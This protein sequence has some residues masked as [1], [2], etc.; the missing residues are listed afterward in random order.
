MVATPTPRTLTPRALRVARAAYARVIASLGGRFPGGSA[1]AHADVFDAL[2][3]EA[4]ADGGWRAV[5][6]L[7]AAEAGSLL[8]VALTPSARSRRS[9]ITM[10]FV[11]D[12][13]A[14]LRA[15]TRARGFTVVTVATLALG[16]GVT[17]A[18]FAVFDAV[19]LR[20]LPYHDADRLVQVAEWPTEGGGGNWTVS[21]AA[22]L[23]WKQRASAFASLDARVTGS[24]VLTDAA[25]PQEVRVARVTPG[26]FHTLGATAMR[27]RVFGDADRPGGGC[28]AV[29]SHRLWSLRYAASGTLIGAPIALDGVPCAVIGVLGADTAFD[30][31]PTDIYTLMEFTAASASDNSRSMTALARLSDG[32]SVERA[33]AD[34]EAVAAAVNPERG[35]EGEGWTARVFPLRDIVVRAG[36]RQL[37][38]VSLAAVGVVLLICC[39]NVA[40]LFL[41]RAVARRHEAA[42]RRALG[43]SRWR[44]ARQYLA[45]AL[46]IAVAGGAAGVVIGSWTLRL[47]V[48][49]LPPGVL[50]PELVVSIDWRV[51]LFTAAVAGGSAVVC[52]LLPLASSTPEAADIRSGGRSMTPSR[53]TGLLQNGLL[54]GEIALATVVLGGAALLLVSYTR[55]MDQPPGFDAEGVFT[56][57][58]AL[59]GPRYA[60]PAAVSAFFERTLDATR[61]SPGVRH[62]A[63]VTSLPLGGWLYGTRFTID[64]QASGRVPP[65]A[66]I[67][68]ATPGYFET[69]GIALRSGRSFDASDSAGA[70][71]VAIVNE[72]L[73]RRFVT[74]G[75]ALGR[76][77]R[78]GSP[79]APPV[80]IIG[81]T[82]D[83]KTYGLA[84]APLATPEIY[85]PH[86]QLSAPVMFVAI[87]SDS[88]DAGA[89][90][91]HL[92]AAVRQADPLVPLGAITPMRDRVGASAALQRFRATMIALLGAA[93]CGLA[94]VGVYSIRAR[95]TQARMSEFGLRIAL[96]ATRG[97]I[98]ALSLRS[99]GRLIGLGLFIGLALAVALT[100]LVQSWLFGIDSGQAWIL[101]VPAAL[102]GVA[103]LA[104]SWIPARR[105][106]RSD[107][108]AMLRRV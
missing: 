37:A 67:Q 97:D 51:L 56:A 98:I 7:W 1:D 24:A 91:S 18:G 108:T 76:F 46:L 96:G 66:H 8:R 21:P 10:G 63:A 81:V 14:S 29:V 52:G 70:A 44:T 73:A 62:A 90:L 84:D 26:Y 15:L 31:S 19:L 95:H 33:A 82:A 4:F 25:D 36:A 39:V 87:R 83:V 64:G 11:Q 65:S 53:R 35:A 20:P 71:P 22:F 92:R 93:A 3:Q 101:A 103:G 27:G 57:R 86:T 6:R 2:Q 47:F 88:E 79:D 54:V 78:L 60:E 49:L 59:S 89:V 105:A 48:S 23:E 75:D 42:V 12:L 28:V 85:V 74:G 104:A 69:F 77:L 100:G 13:R 32:V 72:T 17:A 5:C 50:P 45:E 16:V 107:P 43:A 94:L 102:L 58:L 30:R 55:L 40:A 38:V 9:P 68:A 80:Q 99:G 34:M 41:S 61:Q 106:A